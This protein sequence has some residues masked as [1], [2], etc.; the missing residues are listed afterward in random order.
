[1]TD[2]KFK[3][4]VSVYKK[5]V[6]TDSLSGELTLSDQSECDNLNKL[7]S[8]RE[9]FGISLERGDI[10]VGN[11]V[12]ISISPPQ[13][14]LGK[15]YPSIS[16]FLSNGKNRIK[17]PSEYFIFTDKFYSKDVVVPQCT[18]S[19]RSL[20]KLIS[21]LKD[22]A[23]FLDENN[24][25]LVYFDK[26]VLKVPI[27]YD[28]S[29]LNKVKIAE[30]ESFISLFVDDTHRDQK[31]SILSNSIKFIADTKEK[32][33]SFSAIISEFNNIIESYKKGYNI[34]SSGFSYEKIIDQLRV[35]KVEEM[36]KIHKT[37][38]DIQNQ[39]LGLPL[40][41]IIVATQMKAAVE[42]D[43]Q[44]FINSAILLGAIVFIALLILV[45]CNQWQT[46][47]AISDEIAYKKDQ[48]KNNYSSIYSDIKT[49]FS[50]LT[51]R[52]FI[53][54]A[55]FIVIG[56]AAIIGFILTVKF[57]FQLTP[58]AYEYIF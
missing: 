3:D 47:R 50:H 40:A 12:L 35:A 56:T 36:G 41:T 27:K 38:S 55:A 33:S 49:T 11:V 53:Q 2:K 57:Y 8:E 37:F 17:E 48:A 58:Y 10:A 51:R 30:I 13:L 52:I 6:L 29:D 4:L 9:R 54:R 1:M 24:Y 19:Y 18:Q 45:L 14:K 5:V 43:A 25:E 46:L 34:F 7:I 39:I 15:I 22:S 23:A 28:L 16:E 21:L 31:L 20:L 26:S 42:W 44:A 32:E